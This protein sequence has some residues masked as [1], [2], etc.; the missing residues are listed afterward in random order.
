MTGGFPHSLIQTVWEVAMDIHEAIG[1]R[2]C[3]FRGEDPDALFEG[4]PLWR[5]ALD[6]VRVAMNVLETFHIDTDT[7]GLFVR[8]GSSPRQ[9]QLGLQTRLHG[10]SSVT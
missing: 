7:D 9:L 1:R 10:L 8:S 6:D 4:R 3:A 2:Y 5:H